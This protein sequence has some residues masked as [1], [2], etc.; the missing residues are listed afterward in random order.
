MLLIHPILLVLQ[1]SPFEYLNGEYQ[2]KKLSRFAR[3]SVCV[4]G[5]DSSFPRVNTASSLLCIQPGDDDSVGITES[6]VSWALGSS[7]I[8]YA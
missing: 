2:A 1:R 3:V 7:H 4:K 8:C 5:S 6:A